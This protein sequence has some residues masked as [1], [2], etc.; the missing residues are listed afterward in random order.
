M[1]QLK[2]FEVT[3]TTSKDRPNNELAKVSARPSAWR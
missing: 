3:N 2:E 1:E